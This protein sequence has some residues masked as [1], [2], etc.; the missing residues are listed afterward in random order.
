[1]IS[2]YSME[3]IT[4]PAKIREEQLCDRDVTL[5]GYVRGTHLRKNTP[6]HIPGGYH[7]VWL[8]S[9]YPLPFSAFLISGSMPPLPWH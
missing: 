7:F 5:Y 1:M 6:V 2:C 4:D 3:D 9:R 8:G